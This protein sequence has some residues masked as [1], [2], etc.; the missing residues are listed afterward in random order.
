MVLTRLDIGLYNNI[1]SKLDI[2]CE[3]WAEQNLDDWQNYSSW[4]I[5]GDYV[6]IHYFFFDYYDN[7]DETMDSDY[8]RVKIDEI[9]E[10]AKTI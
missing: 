10:F 4:S 6:L 2:V 5:E 1:L 7:I 9:L 3:K 8:T